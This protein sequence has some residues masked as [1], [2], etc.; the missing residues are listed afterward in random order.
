MRTEKETSY[1]AIRFPACLIKYRGHAQER[2]IFGGL[3]WLP[4]PGVLTLSAYAYQE[5]VSLKIPAY[6]R[7]SAAPK[8]H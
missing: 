4:R 2:D 5:G 7:D 6:Q 8:P 1:S 3:P